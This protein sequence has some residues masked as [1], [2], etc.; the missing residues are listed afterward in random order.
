M[1]EFN[2]QDYLKYQELKRKKENCIH[3]LREPET[4]YHVH[5]PHDKIL[6]TVLDEK[7]QIVELLNRI[8]QLKEKLTKDD[9]EKY[10]T[11]HINYMFRNSESDVVYKMKKKEIFFLIEHQRKIDYNMPK[12]ILEYEVE[13]IKEAVKGKK[14]TR[15]DHRLPKVI[16]IVIYTGSGKWNV[17]KYIEECQETLT[18]ENSI[19]LG[20]Y[21]V[22]DVN[23]YTNEELEQDQFFLSKILLLEK[24]KTE[25]EIFTMFNKTIEEEKDENN[26]IILK[27][28]IAFI[29]EEKLRPEDKKLL[30][31]KL[32]KRE[33]KDMVLEVIRKENERQRSEGRK[34]GILET[35][36]K[37]LKRNMSIKEI[38]EI[39]GISKEKLEK[40]VAKL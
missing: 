31:K 34:E 35:A 39:T 22:V 20:E 7:T 38:E 17:E 32:E 18:E 10:K 33:E 8:L 12:R 1:K 29:L 24:L 28:I 26:Q 3:E 9:I 36:K 21:Y 13:I 4:K 23:D 2:Y 11:E 25:K 27:R 5:Q 37:M 40:M 15:Q 14:M 30:L 6:K 19:K 16:P